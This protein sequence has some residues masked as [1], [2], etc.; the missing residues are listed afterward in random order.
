MAIKDLW[1]MIH[2]FAFDF[3]V[4]R[5]VAQQALSLHITKAK[6]TAKHGP[7]VPV[8]PQDAGVPLHLGWNTEKLKN[9]RDSGLIITL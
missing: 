6:Q 4:F 8:V 5:C 3:A 7:Q 2:D 1:P 9:H